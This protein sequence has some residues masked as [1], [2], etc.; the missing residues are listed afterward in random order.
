MIF[1][2]T[3]IENKKVR[4]L[5]QKFE[6]L[7]ICWMDP[8]ASSC[9]KFSYESVSGW[10]IAQLL[11]IEYL[12]N[13]LSIDSD[14]QSTGTITVYVRGWTILHISELHFRLPRL[15]KPDLLCKPGDGKCQSDPSPWFW[16]FVSPKLSLS[17]ISDSLAICLKLNWPVNS[18]IDLS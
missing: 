14:Q 16:S 1:V 11:L 9:I 4:N 7:I 10:Y 13:P 12:E 18:W 6:K 15:F 5:S 8:S 3:R 2:A 17:S